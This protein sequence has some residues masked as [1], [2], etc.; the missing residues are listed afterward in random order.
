MPTTP[1][2]SEERRAPLDARTS[3]ARAVPGQRWMGPCKAQVDFCNKWPQTSS[4]TGGAEPQQ[5]PWSKDGNVASWSV[6]PLPLP[7]PPYT[8]RTGTATHTASEAQSYLEGR[9][10]AGS[11]TASPSRTAH[12][13]AGAAVH[14]FH[15]PFHGL[16][17]RASVISGDAWPRST[18]GLQGRGQGV[19]EIHLLRRSQNHH[20][21]NRFWISSGFPIWS[22]PLKSTVA[23]SRRAGNNGAEEQAH[24]QAGPGHGSHQTIS[25]KRKTIRNLFAYSSSSRPHPSQRC[26]GS[27]RGPPHPL[28]NPQ[29]LPVAAARP[30]A[31]IQAR[32]NRSH[33][34]AASSAWSGPRL[35]MAAPN[36]AWDR[37]GCARQT[38]NMTANMPATGRLSRDLS[39]WS[40]NKSPLIK[41]VE[42]RAGTGRSA[43]KP[44]EPGSFFG[45][46]YCTAPHGAR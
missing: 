24:T 31:A 45:R 18:S 21:Q 35:G 3:K 26:W 38:S 36:D 28:P 14:A 19:C 41:G 46:G 2:I 33:V 7:P 25:G 40:S 10:C 4:W 44:W 39:H 6:K 42:C 20:R 23:S 22:G 34:T 43:L 29:A 11:A 30:P 5:A 15:T 9:G 12:S 37:A 1:T 13:C 27:P 8:R 17:A 16:H 32:A